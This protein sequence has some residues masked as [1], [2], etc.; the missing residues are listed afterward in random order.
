M[1]RPRSLA[2]PLLLAL[3]ASGMTSVAWA[4]EPTPEG[5]VVPT[6]S[7]SAGAAAAVAEGPEVAPIDGMPSN[8]L[9]P[10]LFP[11]EAAADDEAAV[12]A[13]A[14]SRG[15]GTAISRRASTSRS[16]GLLRPTMA[17]VSGSREARSS[18][19]GIEGPACRAISSS[20]AEASNGRSASGT[21]SRRNTT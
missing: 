13:R 3:V 7:A 9:D 14:P 8:A 10:S 18:E 4:D 15:S 5:E 21:P 2:L 6:A 16:E 17:S 12:E 11:D 20:S 1:S 19:A